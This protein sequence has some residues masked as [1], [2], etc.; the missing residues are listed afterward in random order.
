MVYYLVYMIYVTRQVAAACLGI[1][2][3]K[4]QSNFN[5]ARDSG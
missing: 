5:E 1:P 2:E 3:R 4:K